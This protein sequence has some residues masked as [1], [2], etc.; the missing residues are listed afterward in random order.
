MAVIYRGPWKP[1]WTCAKLLA[2]ADAQTYEG[3]AKAEGLVLKTDGL[4]LRVSVKI[5][6]NRFL[7]QHGL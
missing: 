7:L 2:M 4:G 1:D 3:G 5:I 6:S